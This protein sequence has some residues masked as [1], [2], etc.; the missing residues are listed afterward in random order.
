MLKG[1]NSSNAHTVARRDEER[2]SNAPSPYGLSPYVHLVENRLVP[3]V[4]GYGA[5][6]QLSGEV[7]E[8]R[9]ELM[10]LMVHLKLGQKL[11]LREEERRSAAAQ[12]GPIGWLLEKEFLVPTELDPL[13]SFTNHYVVRP[14]QNPALAHTSGDGLL[15]LT[16]I[17]MSQRLFSPH[18]DDLPPIIE[19]VMDELAAEI[20]LQADGTKTLQEIFE[21]M[22][23][24]MGGSLL[25]ERGFRETLERLTRPDRQLIKLAPRREN[26]ADPYQPFNTVPRDLAHTSKGEERAQESGATETVKE[27]H[28]TGIEDAWWEFDFIEP[29]VNHC[30]RFPSDVFGGLDYAS[31]FCLSALKPEVLPSLGT[32]TQ[33][34][35]LEIGG[36]TGTFAKSFIEQAT[37]LSTSLLAGREL[38]YHIVELSPALMMNQQRLLADCQLPVTHFQQD[39]TELDLPGREF[40]LMIANE[41]IADFP[42]ASVS[43]GQQP[44]E[45]SDAEFAQPGR[46]WEGEGAIYVEKYQLPVE[47]AP[48]SFLVHAG[49]FQFLERAWKHLS[50]GGTLILTEY[51]SERQYPVRAYHLNHEEFAIHF[52]QVVACAT[53][54]GFIC[55]LLTLREFL[56]ADDTVPILNGREEHLRCLNQVLRKYGAGLPFAAISEREFQERCGPLAERINLIGPTFSPLRTGFHYGPDFN[57][58][59]ALILHK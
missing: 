45:A 50:K 5:F 9:A 6:H 41:V 34:R 23:K 58:F 12:G 43:R 3:P 27:F 54:I 36:G 35:V 51:G 28:L 38:S 2:M 18:R 39:A 21:K 53:S 30:F 37:R 10:P 56:E 40:D 14:V 29:T 52:A 4:I 48:D 33:L 15:R 57:E 8:I 24:S 47:D 7:L 25:Q 44:E 16:R 11:M 42:V 1:L 46:R 49:V 13:A 26:L 22:K 20:F 31:R 55:R 59:M 19:E 17:N 32:T